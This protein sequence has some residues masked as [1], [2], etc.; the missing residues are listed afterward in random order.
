MK[1]KKPQHLRLSIM[2]AR[3]IFQHESKF[4][5]KYGRRLN[6]E[7]SASNASNADSNKQ[8]EN[9]ASRFSHASTG[10]TSNNPVQKKA[11][12]QSLSIHNQG[13]LKGVGVKLDQREMLVREDKWEENIVKQDEPT[14]NNQLVPYPSVERS[15]YDD[16]PTNADIDKIESTK[17]ES[18]NQESRVMSIRL[19]QKQEESLKRQKQ[20]EETEGHERERVKFLKELEDQE[21]HKI[22]TEYLQQVYSQ[23]SQPP[24]PH[25]GNRKSEYSTPTHKGSK[26]GLDFSVATKPAEEQNPDVPQVTTRPAPIWHQTARGTQGDKK[27]SFKAKQGITG[28]NGVRFFNE[29]NNSLFIEYINSPGEDTETGKDKD[30]RQVNAKFLRRN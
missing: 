20:K 17:A 9:Q 18:T 6:T 15:P 7:A 16:N 3:E 12:E 1:N 8:S 25:A 28:T 23:N 30:K 29:W 22:I 14:H 26:Q 4:H 19:N 2:Q 11:N 5:A 21:R 27:I 13:Y 24:S 10:T